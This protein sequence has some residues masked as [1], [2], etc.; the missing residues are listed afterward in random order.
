MTDDVALRQVRMTE[1]ED[2]GGGRLGRR[3]AGFVT[4]RQRVTAA[5]LPDGLFS[6][7]K[8]HCG[9]ILEG[10]WNGKCYDHL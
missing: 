2:G 8:S 7:Q 6:S 3:A 9:Y 1:N 10:P 4:R 5:G